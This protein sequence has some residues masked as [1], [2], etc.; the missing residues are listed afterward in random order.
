MTVISQRTY[1]LINKVSLLGLHHE[2]TRTDDGRWVIE[3]SE[4][5]I[6][7][8]DERRLPGESD[9]DLIFRVINLAIQKAIGGMN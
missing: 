4:E 1:D 2:G 6:E 8:L 7:R 9:D 3:L 5:T